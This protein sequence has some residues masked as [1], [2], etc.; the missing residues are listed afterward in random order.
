MREREKEEIQRDVQ[1]QKENACE[2]E[3]EMIKYDERE[4]EENRD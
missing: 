1:I 3:R 4:G 2:R